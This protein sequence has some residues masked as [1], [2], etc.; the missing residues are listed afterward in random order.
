MQLDQKTAEM[1]RRAY[2][3]D[4]ADAVGLPESLLELH[5]RMTDTLWLVARQRNDARAIAFT[6]IL[7]QE[8]NP[9]QHAEFRR[10]IQRVQQGAGDW[11]EQWQDV[12][13]GTPVVADGKPGKFFSL[14]Q[15]STDTDAGLLYVSIDGDRGKYKKIPYGN[16][17]IARETAES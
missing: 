5:D 9:K 17:Q 11:V 3:I 15:G 16:V 1:Y 13:K 8:L 2:N 7:W 10:Q 6:V 12:K 14:P 4:A